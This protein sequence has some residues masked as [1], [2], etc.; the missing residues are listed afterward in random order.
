LTSSLTKRYSRNF[1]FQANY[2]FSK[3]IDD[4]TD[5][6]SQFASFT[7]TRLYLERG[8]SSFNIKHNFVA[9]AVYTT[10]GPRWVSGFL[11]SPIVTARSGIP[12]SVTVP[13][14]QNGTLGH[15]LYARPWT[16]PRNSGI[17]PAFYSFDMRLSKAF[18]LKPDSAARIEIS[19]EAT[20]LLNHTNFLSV[21]N[22]FS[23][24]DPRLSTPG[25]DF[26]GSRSISSGDPLG[27]TSASNARQFQFGL[28]LGF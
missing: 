20:N 2:T 14:A 1:Q 28:K 22:T 12:F 13:G 23:P 5:F 17:G 9:S 19:A 21:N 10:H 25:F 3:S 15:S 7:P 16:I 27:F 18:I 8:L 26:T 24:G 4:V 6:N 11:L